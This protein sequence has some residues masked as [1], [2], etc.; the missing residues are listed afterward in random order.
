MRV[1]FLDGKNNINIVES[2]NVYEVD[3][4]ITVHYNYTGFGQEFRST[5]DTFHVDNAKEL[6][7]GAF[8]TGLL[9]LTKAKLAE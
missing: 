7:I 9:D 2:F 4:D 5:A 1:K 3:N 8:E 6:L